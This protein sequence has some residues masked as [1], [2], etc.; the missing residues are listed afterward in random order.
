VFGQAVSFTAAV[1]GIVGGVPRVIGGTVTF[2]V[3]GNAWATRVLNTSSSPT[4][5]LASIQL[6]LPAGSHTI[7]ARYNGAAAYAASS[8][9]GRNEQVNPANTHTVLSSNHNPAYIGQVT[10]MTATVRANAPGG[11][12][13]QGTVTFKVDGADAGTVNLNP[14]TGQASLNLGALSQ[15][16]HLISAVYN[17]SGNHNGGTSPLYGQQVRPAA[18]LTT[19]VVSSSGGVNAPFTI[20]AVARGA[21]N[22]LVPGFSGPATLTVLSVPTSGAMVTGSRTSAFSGGVA[23]FAGL[24]VNKTGTYKVRISS[25]GLFV[26]LTISV[27]DRVTA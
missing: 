6:A 20:Q 19:R 1:S 8:S 2:L 13:P 22:S 21:D 16:T 25:G 24:S 26:D 10:V 5:G 12:I 9:V 15:G 14:T 18:K 27:T 3:D 4:Y 23:T 11:G 7:Q 17:G